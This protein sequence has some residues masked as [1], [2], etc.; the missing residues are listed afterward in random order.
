LS[1]NKTCHYELNEVI[2]PLVIHYLQIASPNIFWDR[3]DE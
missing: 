2:S 3:N 1:G